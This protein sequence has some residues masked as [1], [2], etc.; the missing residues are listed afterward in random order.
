MTMPRQLITACA[1]LTL[2][3]AASGQTNSSDS[4]NPED[5][6]ASAAPARDQLLFFRGFDNESDRQ[7]L[8]ESETRRVELLR[9]QLAD[10]A[11][12]SKLRAE[13][14]QQHRAQLPD[15]ARVVGMDAKTE[16]RLLDLLADRQLAGELVP[17]PWATTDTSPST[18]ESI[19]E[20]A[21]QAT[22]D[23]TRDMDEIAALL[24]AEAPMERYVD[25]Q[26]ALQHRLRVERFSSRLPVAQQ[27]SFDQ[28]NRMVGVLMEQEQRDR[29]RA[30]RLQPQL[31]L[32]DLGNT[33]EER[34]R[35]MAEYLIVANERAMANREAADRDL[36]QQLT[37][38][39]SPPQSAAFASMLQEQTA[40]ARR[41]SQ[42]QRSELGI[43]PDQQ[44]QSRGVP[45][46]PLP[47]LTANVR[48][49]IDI[50]VNGTRTSHSLQ[51]VRGGAVSFDGAGLTVKA[52]PYLNRDQTL[53]LEYSFYEPI[54]GGGRRLAGISFG[55][56]QLIDPRNQNSSSK[57]ELAQAWGRKGYAIDLQVK[58]A[59]Q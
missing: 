33:R 6:S 14:A 12:R 8:I 39:L 30:R 16:A 27:L 7:Q 24:G 58:A 48:L 49:T 42:A 15:I 23:Y 41:A 37:S 31:P 19:D 45:A 1:L 25:Y 47:A 44:I 11:Q 26:Q 57:P 10:P 43:G 5:N 46:A 17:S 59:Y 22:V 28:K 4:T 3:C 52:R 2:A 9:Q 54:P 53:A 29:E 35:N 50:T 18:Q 40:A 13:R 21:R 55:N 51:S 38:V 34:D 20:R 36:L 56:A 32:G